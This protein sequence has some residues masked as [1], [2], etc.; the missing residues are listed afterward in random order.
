M[1][2]TILK[3]R[4]PNFILI[5]APKLQGYTELGVD[6][7]QG[8]AKILSPYQYTHIAA[9]QAWYASINALLRPFKKFKVDDRVIPWCTFTDPE[10]ARVGLNEIEA[11]EKGIAFHVTKYGIE[12]LDRALVDGE[13]QGFIKILTQPGRDKILGAAI[14][15]P[16]AGDC[17]I[18]YILA[19]KYGFGLNKILNTIHIYPTYSEA[20][21]YAAGLWKNVHKPEKLLRWAKRFHHWR[22]GGEP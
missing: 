9:H 1:V 11:K 22:L 17:I 3:R 16:H 7:L 6:C 20:N 8:K 12:D 13:D 21:K 18:E 10:M 5:R 19:M 14:V 15:G 2:N 4:F